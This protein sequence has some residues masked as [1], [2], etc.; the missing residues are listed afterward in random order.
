MGLLLLFEI[1]AKFYSEVFKDSCEANTTEEVDHFE[2]L[3]VVRAEINGVGDE[4][5][6]MVHVKKK[7]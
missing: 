2:Y 3:D 1:Q 7:S 5:S 6:W 4:N